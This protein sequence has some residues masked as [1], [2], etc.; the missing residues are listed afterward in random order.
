MFVQM[1]SIDVR[2]CWFYVGYDFETSPSTTTILKLLHEPDHKDVEMQDPGCGSIFLRLPYLFLK[3]GTET[4]EKILL[5]LLS[6]DIG[7]E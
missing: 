2:I 5:F 7:Y 3:G 4:A 6:E 1:K